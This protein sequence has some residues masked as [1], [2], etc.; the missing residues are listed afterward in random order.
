[1]WCFHVSYLQLLLW[2][3]TLK[4]LIVYPTKI[5]LFL[6]FLF[7]KKIFLI[8]SFYFISKQFDVCVWY[9][10][11]IFFSLQL[12]F[13]NEFHTLFLSAKTS[14]QEWFYKIFIFINIQNSSKFNSVIFKIVSIKKIFPTKVNQLS[15]IYK[16]HY[17]KL[18]KKII[19]KD[20]FNILR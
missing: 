8:I 12:F 13:S 10:I 7:D 17:Y 15:M 4:L 18:E 11:I 16:L 20:K 6:C 3:L 9:F 5:F 2:M 1:M 19:I 14:F